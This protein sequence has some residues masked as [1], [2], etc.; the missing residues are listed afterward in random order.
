LTLFAVICF[1]ASLLQAIAQTLPQA[2]AAGSEGEAVALCTADGLQLIDPD[3]GKPP[4]HKTSNHHDHCPGCRTHHVG[5]SYLPSAVVELVLAAMVESGLG[6][7][8]VDQATPSLRDPAR[9]P[10]APPVFL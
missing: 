6:D 8:R 9:Q 7:D 10:R 2:E 3:T 4:A 1:L 5:V